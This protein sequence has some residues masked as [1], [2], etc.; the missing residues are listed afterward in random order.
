MNLTASA[1]FGYSLYENR[2]EN[3]YRHRRFQRNRPRHNPGVPRT[4]L[5]GRGYL[6]RNQ[7]V[8]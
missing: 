6:P 8:G 5:A 1:F 7:Q 3:S 2:N 4:R